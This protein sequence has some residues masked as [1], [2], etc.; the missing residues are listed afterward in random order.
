VIERPIGRCAPPPD[1]APGEP[2]IG[3]LEGTSDD[4]PDLLVGQRLEPPDAQPRQEG[5]VHLE[6]GV[7][8]RR[9]DE[10]DGPILDVGE[11]RVLLGLVEP[12]DLVD[13]Q[14]AAHARHGRL[15][16]RLGDDG[17]DLGHA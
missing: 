14:D 7:L 5:R 15:L 8:G 3:V 11:Q 4:R 12:V 17:A 16:P 1:R 13:E 6:I 10:R 2:A 9:P